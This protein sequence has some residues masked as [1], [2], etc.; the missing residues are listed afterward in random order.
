MLEDEID[1]TTSHCNRMLLQILSC[2]RDES[3][4][5]N[6]EEAAIIARQLKLSTR[7]KDDCT[8]FFE[9]FGKRNFKQIKLVSIEKTS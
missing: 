5:V 8:I 3:D 6:R 9:V 4:N 1:R 7:R 2:I